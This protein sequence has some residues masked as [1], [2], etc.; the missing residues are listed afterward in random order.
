MA[1]LGRVQQRFN[2]AIVAVLALLK[3]G[4]GSKKE[5]ARAQGAG[6]PILAKLIKSSSPNANTPGR[7]YPGYCSGQRE[8]ARRA[9]AI[10]GTQ[11]AE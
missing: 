1:G 11:L 5:Q 4:A 7:E 6:H 10:I 9:A 3:V 8:T 2:A